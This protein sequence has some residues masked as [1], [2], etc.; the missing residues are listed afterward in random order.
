[1]VYFNS[2]D[3]VIQLSRGNFP[4]YSLICT[5]PPTLDNL[6]TCVSWFDHM[7]RLVEP[8]RQVDIKIGLIGNLSRR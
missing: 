5:C 6:P 8:G 1:M 7:D 3:H 2:I 4:T